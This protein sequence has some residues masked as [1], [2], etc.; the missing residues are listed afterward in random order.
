LSA[1]S[2]TIIIPTD[3]KAEYPKSF[4]GSEVTSPIEGSET[5]SKESVKIPQVILLID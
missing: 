4:N 2:P 1:T 5:T 3:F